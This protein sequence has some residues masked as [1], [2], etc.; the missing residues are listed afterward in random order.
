[1]TRKSISHIALL[2]FSLRVGFGGAWVEERSSLCAPEAAAIHKH[3]CPSGN[4]TLLLSA[5][6]AELFCALR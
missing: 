1:M 4:V 3:A 5:R 2:S 6:I